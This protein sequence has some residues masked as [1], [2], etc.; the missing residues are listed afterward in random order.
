MGE[1]RD[2]GV[3][4]EEVLLE[5]QALVSMGFYLLTYIDFERFSLLWLVVVGCFLV[6]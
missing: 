3:E 1:D 2:G 6:S 5:Q 4:R